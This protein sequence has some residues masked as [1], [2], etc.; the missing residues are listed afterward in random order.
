M[1]IVPPYIVAMKAANVIASMIRFFMS[2]P[3]GAGGAEAPVG[4]AAS[5]SACIPPSAYIRAA[6][7]EKP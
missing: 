2:F 7:L 6:V 3:F 1:M 4:Y 5:T